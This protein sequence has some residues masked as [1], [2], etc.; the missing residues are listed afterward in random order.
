MQLAIC[1]RRASPAAAT[2]H[3]THMAW[4]TFSAAL[5][6]R[7]VRWTPKSAPPAAAAQAEVQYGEALCTPD[8]LVAAV[9]GAGFE[10]SGGCASL[11]RGCGWL[12]LPSLWSL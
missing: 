4:F 5:P 8:Q 2:V 7:L 6:L 9:E 1:M 12:L 10:A 11:A 3:H